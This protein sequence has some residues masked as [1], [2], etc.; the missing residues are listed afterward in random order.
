MVSESISGNPAGPAQAN[1]ER[2]CDHSA[3]LSFVNFGWRGSAASFAPNIIG[4]ALFSLALKNAND[5]F[6]IT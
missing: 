4:N 2:L 5:R 1:A 6:H 3:R